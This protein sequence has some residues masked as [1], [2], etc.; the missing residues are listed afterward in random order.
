MPN[1]NAISSGTQFLIL[2]ASNVISVIRG[3]GK[4][5]LMSPYDAHDMMSTGCPRSYRSHAWGN[6]SREVAQMNEDPF[7]CPSPMS[8]AQKEK[9]PVFQ[10]PAQGG[11]GSHNISDWLRQHKLTQCGQCVDHC[12]RILNIFRSDRSVCLPSPPMAVLGPYALRC[13]NFFPRASFAFCLLPLNA[14]EALSWMFFVYRAVLRYDKICWNLNNFLFFLTLLKCAGLLPGSLCER[15]R[16]AQQCQLQS[17]RPQVLC[18]FGIMKT[19]KKNTCTKFTKSPPRSQTN[20]LK[21]FTKKTN[22]I[23]SNIKPICQI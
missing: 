10:S 1:W 3:R 5:I 14:P 9:L 13:V 15:L 20:F 11:C 17:Q 8:A 6:S 19:F 18:R 2:A 23:C 22:K 12:A 21:T 16:S 4:I 7:F